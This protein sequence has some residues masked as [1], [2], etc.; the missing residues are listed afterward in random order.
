M[1]AGGTSANAKPRSSGRTAWADG[2]G[3]RLGVGGIEVTNV[4][5]NQNLWLI[6]GSATLFLALSVGISL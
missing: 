1:A 6:T 2:S 5:D 3:D 4:L